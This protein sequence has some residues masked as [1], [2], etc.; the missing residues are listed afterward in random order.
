M[1]NKKRSIESWGLDV[2]DGMS[3]PNG[4]TA[5]RPS[6]PAEGELRGNTSHKSLE[7]FIGNAWRVSQNKLT[8]VS[9]RSS[10]FTAVVNTM[11]PVSTS[12]RTVLA[13][14]PAAQQ[15]DRIIF[16]D[17]SGTWDSRAFSVRGPSGV[18][19]DFQTTRSHNIE[20]DT[21]VYVFQGNRWLLEGGA[22]PPIVDLSGVGVT[23]PKG[24]ATVSSNVTAVVGRGQIVNVTTADA[25]IILPVSAKQGDK[26]G[27]L[28]TGSDASLL[29][30]D[31]VIRSGGKIN[32]SS[33]DIVIH[34]TNRLM[35][36]EWMGT[37][38]MTISDTRPV[39]GHMK[40]PYALSFNAVGARLPGKFFV[41]GNADPFKP[42]TIR[43]HRNFLLE[44]KSRT[45]HHHGGT[46]AGNGIVQEIRS[47]SNPYVFTRFSSNGGSSWTQFV[48]EMP[49]IYDN[50]ATGTRSFGGGFMSYRLTNYTNATFNFDN[51]SW[52]PGAEITITNLRSSCTLTINASVNITALDGSTS[53]SATMTGKGTVV[54]RRNKANNG[55]NV[56]DSTTQE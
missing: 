34:E 9:T 18:Q 15:G 33:M 38:W 42:A 22:E 3:I 31:A 2:L 27:A 47:E 50:T 36:F 52:T 43:A 20:R 48:C 41:E 49:Y 8:Q 1:G 23:L 11:V 16:Y 21:V 17:A 28:F 7:A 35:V 53:T 19:I 14:M 56:I 40:L 55:F 12:S 5:Q 29:A 13:T 39:T 4:S 54:L 26:I 30:H 24:W 10:N 51:I 44:N 45:S 6:S 25:F 32:M 46:A 37:S